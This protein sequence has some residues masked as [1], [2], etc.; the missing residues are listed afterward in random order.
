[1]RRGSPHYIL[2]WGF[3]IMAAEAR[4]A[5][6]ILLVDDEPAVRGLAKLIL[7]QQGWSVGEA[8]SL[9]EAAAKLRAEPGAFALAVVDLQLPDGLGPD[10]ARQFES[11]EG[12]P[13]FVYITG[14][15]G[16]LQRITGRD[17]FVLPKPFTPRQ[18]A[19]VARTALDARARK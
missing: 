17:G 2:V 13:T 3:L 5:V 4:A 16:A 6:R 15:P 8:G 7:Q 18:L 12:A 19:D 9:E 1:V 14:D 10:L 11:V